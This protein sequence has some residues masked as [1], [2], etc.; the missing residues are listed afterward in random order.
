MRARLRD[1][2]NVDEDNGAELPHGLG[3]GLSHDHGVTFCSS[4]QMSFI[5]AVNQRVKEWPCYLFNVRSLNVVS[6][7]PRWMKSGTVIPPSECCNQWLSSNRSIYVEEE[8]WYW[9]K[10]ELWYWRYSGPSELRNRPAPADKT[11]WEESKNLHGMLILRNYESPRKK[12]RSQTNCLYL[13]L[14]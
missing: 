13:D 9:D 8:S 10:E 5:L 7:P 14:S 3:R 4:A 11:S 1:T 2:S 6:V 12:W